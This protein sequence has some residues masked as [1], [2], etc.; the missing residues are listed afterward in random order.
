MTQLYLWMEERWLMMLA[1]TVLPG[2]LW[3]VGVRLRTGMTM[4]VWA[5]TGVVAAASRVA[6]WFEVL[7]L[8]LD[9]FAVRWVRES[10]APRVISQVELIAREGRD[11]SLQGLPETGAGRTGLERMA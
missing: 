10:R 9:S 8:A 6:R 11:G 7:Y 2:G 5:L 1:V 4:G 3:L